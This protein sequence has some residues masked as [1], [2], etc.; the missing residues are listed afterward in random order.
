MVREEGSHNICGMQQLQQEHLCSSTSEY[1]RWSYANIQPFLYL[2]TLINKVPDFSSHPIF[3]KEGK[4]IKGGEKRYTYKAR[5][6]FYIKR[7]AIK[8]KYARMVKKYIYFLK[9]VCNN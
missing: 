3:H 1:N 7:Q 5:R 4:R 8:L 6:V 2:F 9:A